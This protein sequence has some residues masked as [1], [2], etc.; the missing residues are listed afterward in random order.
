MV[1]EP[2]VFEL[3]RFDSRLSL[4]RNPRDSL[5][6]LYPFFDIPEVRDILK[7]LRKRGAIS[8]VLH[9]ILFP[10]VRVPC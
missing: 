3:L 4:S 7:T 10:V 9:N 5:N 6:Y 1:N 2:S 8:P